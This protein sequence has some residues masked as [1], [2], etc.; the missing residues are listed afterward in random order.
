ML[1]L[2]CEAR[3]TAQKHVETRPAL[4][5]LQCFEL[6]ITGKSINIKEIDLGSNYHE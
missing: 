4:P 6:N 5:E 3:L 2:D 1:R